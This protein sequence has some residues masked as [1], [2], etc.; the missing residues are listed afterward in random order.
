MEPTAIAVAAVTEP[1]ILKDPIPYGDSQITGLKIAL[2]TIKKLA[3]TSGRHSIAVAYKNKVEISGIEWDKDPDLF[4]FD[5]KIMNL[6]TGEFVQ[7]VKKQYIKPPVDGI[8]MIIMILIE[9]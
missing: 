1:P 9:I 4:A 7:P 2:K 8:G 5:N 6:K 3:S